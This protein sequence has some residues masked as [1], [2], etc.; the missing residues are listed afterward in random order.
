MFFDTAVSIGL[1]RCRITAL[2]DGPTALTEVDDEIVGFKSL[3]TFIDD[4]QQGATLQLTAV[5]GS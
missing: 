5:S 1:E 2:G 3:Q 4:L